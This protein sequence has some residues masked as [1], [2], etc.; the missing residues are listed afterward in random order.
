[1]AVKNKYL[2]EFK[3]KQDQQAC[4]IEPEYYRY[5]DINRHK[6]HAASHLYDYQIIDAL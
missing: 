1:M 3:L 4:S 5:L 2:F 6:V